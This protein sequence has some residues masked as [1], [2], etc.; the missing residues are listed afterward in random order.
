[1]GVNS[2]LFGRRLF[3]M[4]LSQ[5]DQRQFNQR[6]LVNV[7]FGE[8]VP[9]LPIQIVY[10]SFVAGG[11]GAVSSAAIISSTLSVFVAILDFLSKRQLLSDEKVNQCLFS[12]KVASAEPTFIENR[13]A[14]RHRTWNLPQ[15]IASLFPMDRNAVEILPMDKFEDK[16]HT[17]L[18]LTFFISTSKYY[19]K[20]LVD[21]LKAH[22]LDD[23]SK[24]VA[25][26]WQL[27]TARLSLYEFKEVMVFAQDRRDSQRMIEL[28]I[29]ELDDSD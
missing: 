19:R 28:N 18:V 23:L 26:A 3:C 7:V 6:R 24:Q 15:E 17:G 1:M 27:D 29:E 16:E 13:S 8:N 12:V 10:A 5:H 14:F 2:N 21:T 20:E 9:Q 4:G 25:K 11:I 22:R